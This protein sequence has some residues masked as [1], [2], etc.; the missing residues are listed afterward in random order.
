M[1]NEN[2]NVYQRK[3]LRKEMIVSAIIQ[4]RMNSKRLPGKIMMEI[5]NKP[6]LEILIE[7]VRQCKTLDRIIIATT[8][9]KEDDVIEEFCI[10]KKINYVRGSEKD[11][12]SRHLLAAKETDVIVRITSDNPL[13]DPAIIDKG[14]KIYLENEFDFVS[15]YVPPPR[16]FPDGM[17]VEIF[18][19]NL[20]KEVNKKAKKPSE[21]EHVTF[22]IWKQPEKFKIYRFEHG[23][24]L[25]GYRFTLDYLEDFKVIEA[26]LNSLYKKNPK[27]G[28]EDI[29]NWLEEHSEIKN[30][31]THIKPNQGWNESLHQDKKLGY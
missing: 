14:V 12:L 2:S 6:I 10:K 19:N 28:L 5:R 7:R 20:L 13:I 17:A 1:N 29:I 25:S 9:Q 15:N 30:I 31:N 21:R 23:I 27:F 16:T 4:A 3:K 24:D 18:S 11:V 26:I 22:F 8:E